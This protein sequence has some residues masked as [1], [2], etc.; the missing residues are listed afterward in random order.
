[1]LAHNIRSGFDFT[2]VKR[3]D[4]RSAQPVSAFGMGFLA[5]LYGFGRAE[6]TPIKSSA[7]GIAR[8]VGRYISRHIGNRR[9]ADK[10]ARLVRYPNIRNH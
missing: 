9:L 2:A 4:C 5:P 7:E 1:M 8:Y 3:K 6:M 10:G